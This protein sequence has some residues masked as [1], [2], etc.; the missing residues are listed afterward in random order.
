MDRASGDAVSLILADDTADTLSQSVGEQLG[1]DFIII[2]ETGRQLAKSAR[3][4][5]LGNKVIIALLKERGR[6]PVRKE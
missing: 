5:F 4:P 1:K 2:I 3:S 6:E